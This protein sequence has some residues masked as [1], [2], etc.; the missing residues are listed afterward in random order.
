MSGYSQSGEDKGPAKEPE[1]NE[2]QGKREA[3]EG[4]VDVSEVD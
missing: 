1:E 3:E 4:R 2:A